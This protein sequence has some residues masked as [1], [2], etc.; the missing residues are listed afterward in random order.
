MQC[1]RQCIQNSACKSIVLDHSQSDV[2]C[3]MFDNS[4]VG[5][6]LTSDEKWILTKVRII[7]SCGKLSL[8]GLALTTTGRGQK[9][10]PGI[11]KF[12]LSF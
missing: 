8:M 5:T 11:T 12:S 1:F 3:D 7:P 2:A 6:T 9:N 10:P 4:D